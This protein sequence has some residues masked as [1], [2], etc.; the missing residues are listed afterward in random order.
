MVLRVFFQGLGFMLISVLIFFAFMTQRMM[1]KDENAALETLSRKEWLGSIRQSSLGQRAVGLQRWVANHSH[2]SDL[3]S[4]SGSFGSQFA[5]LDNAENQLLQTFSNLGVSRLRR[6]NAFPYS[7][8]ASTPTIST[9]LRPLDVPTDTVVE[10]SVDSYG[11]IKAVPSKQRVPPLAVESSTDSYGAIN[12]VSSKQR[13][14]VVVQNTIKMQANE[15]EQEPSADSYGE[16]VALRK[17]AN[18]QT[19]TGSITNTPVITQSG[20]DSSSNEVKSS[21][22]VFN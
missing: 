13:V 21:P 18:K 7:E 19:T 22:H 1:I 20:G 3:S 17:G 15:E 9:T 6:P 12:A 14:P 2:L 16:I 4:L 5:R 10:S 8:T 11:A